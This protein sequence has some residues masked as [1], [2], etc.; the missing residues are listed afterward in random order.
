M[1]AGVVDASYKGELFVMVTSTHPHEVVV[2]E[3]GSR[4]VAWG[5]V[6]R[7]LAARGDVGEAR[8]SGGFG[9]SG[10]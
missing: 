6:T 9:S 1:V 5:V 10:R 2:G 4:V 3:T 7:V 8:G